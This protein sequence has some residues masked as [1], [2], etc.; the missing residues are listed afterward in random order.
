MRHIRP[1]AFKLLMYEGQPQP[2]AGAHS[3]W[4]WVCPAE[5]DCAAA[6][7]CPLMTACISLLAN[8]GAS[9]LLQPG[10]LPAGRAAKVVT[11]A[12][13]AAADVVLTTYDVLRVSA[14][15]GRCG[16]C[17]AAAASTGLS[18]VDTSRAP[19]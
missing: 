1:G 12:E 14:L 13:L 10:L 15:N 11:A 19:L 17:H 3:G 16:Y 6:G 4:V 9:L 5:P 8:Q 18:C 7:A 2:G